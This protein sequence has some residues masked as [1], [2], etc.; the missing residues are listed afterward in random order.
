MGKW[1]EVSSTHGDGCE[2]CAVA[3]MEAI[4]L[5]TVTRGPGVVRLEGHT[6]RTKIT[7][8]PV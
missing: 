3:E 2:G 1:I 5:S 4:L 8:E 6:A 7:E